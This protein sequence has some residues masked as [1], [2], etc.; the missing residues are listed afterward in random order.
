MSPYK[1]MYTTVFNACTDA[2]RQIEAAQLQLAEAHSAIVAAQQKAE[3]LFIE[4]AE[5]DAP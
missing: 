1:E 3:E 5:E 4:A 2:L